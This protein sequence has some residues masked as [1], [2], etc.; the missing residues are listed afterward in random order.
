MAI[1]PSIDLINPHGR[2]VSVAIERKDGLLR[3]GYREPSQEPE[4]EPEPMT[5]DDEKAELE[6]LLRKMKVQELR[7]M[8]TEA[9]IDIAEHKTKKALVNVLVNH[10][11]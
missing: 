4:P 1:K 7:D 11:A 8:A 5:E 2:L 3:K 6:G 9:G 10:G